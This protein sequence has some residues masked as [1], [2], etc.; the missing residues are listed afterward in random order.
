VGSGQSRS[1]ERILTV[2]TDCAVGKMYT[3]L[4]LEREMR[5]RGLDADFRATGQTGILIAGSGVSVDAV[6][7]DFVS[8]AVEWL[9]PANRANHWDLIEGQGTL[10][11]PGYA[12]VT[13]GLLHGGQ[14]TGLVVCHQA[15]RREIHGVAGYATPTLRE[16]AERHLDAARLTSPGVECVGVS[17]NTSSMVRE[18]RREYLEEIEEMLNVPAVDPLKTG[19]GAIVDGLEK[20]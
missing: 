14:P 19:V 3:V 7:S 18:A 8:G 15:G 5:S 13:L 4:A 9:C 20:R 16:C 1:G 6:V 2:G 11:H 17:V 10:F 12:A